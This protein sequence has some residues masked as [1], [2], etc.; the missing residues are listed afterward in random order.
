M[1]A[2]I[3]SSGRQCY[4]CILTT[5]TPVLEHIPSMQHTTYF[6]VAC[7]CA[8]RTDPTPAILQHRVQLPHGWGQ[9]CEINCTTGK[10]QCMQ[11]LES[12]PGTLGSV[13][14]GPRFKPVGCRGRRPAHRHH[15]HAAWQQGPLRQCRAAHPRREHPAS[16]TQTCLQDPP[17]ACLSSKL[18]SDRVRGPVPS[19]L[20]PINIAA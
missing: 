12:R 6:V 3:F 14:A 8:V 10:P 19:L 9:G 17:P 2:C 13:H 15:G 18:V 1:I 5:S 7:P 20:P 4:L 16:C 11:H